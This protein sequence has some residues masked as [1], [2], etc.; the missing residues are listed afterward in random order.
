MK[1]SNDFPILIFGDLNDP[2][3]FSYSGDTS[4]SPEKLDALLVKPGMHPR[5]LPARS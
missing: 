4:G 2:L 1:E 3:R 5:E